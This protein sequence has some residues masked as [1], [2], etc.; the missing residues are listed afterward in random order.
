MKIQGGNVVVGSSTND[1]TYYDMICEIN[2]SVGLTRST[3]TV[4][5]KCDGGTSARSLGAYEWEISGSAVADNAPTS[6]Q[7]SYKS[8]LAHFVA[9]TLLYVRVQ[10]PGTGSSAGSDYYH[11]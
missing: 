10:S 8:M 2:N 3:N 9:G 6:T 5:T 7:V 4:R 11:K 1:S